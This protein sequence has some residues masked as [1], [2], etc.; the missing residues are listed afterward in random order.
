MLT[1]SSDPSGRAVPEHHVRRQQQ[2]AGAVLGRGQQRDGGGVG[3]RS[4]DEPIYR[5]RGAG[6]VPDQGARVRP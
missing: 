3:E 6:G 5:H 2:A 4:G 1:T